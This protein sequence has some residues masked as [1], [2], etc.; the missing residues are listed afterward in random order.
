MDRLLRSAIKSLVP[1]WLSN[2]PG[3]N[4]GFKV[5]WSMALVGDVII[6]NG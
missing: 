6:E 4:V 5:L 1:N 2:V 3:L